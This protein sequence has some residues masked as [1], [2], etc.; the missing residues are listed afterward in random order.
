LS[1]AGDGPGVLRLDPALDWLN[2]RDLEPGTPLGHWDGQRWPVHALDPTGAN[3]TG[4]YFE[5]SGGALRLRRRVM[6][7]LLSTN[8]R[9]VREDCL[10][11]LTEPLNSPLGA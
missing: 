10:C 2:F 4:H 7:S 3:V 6:P 5:F 8:A 11:Q 1:F 9:A